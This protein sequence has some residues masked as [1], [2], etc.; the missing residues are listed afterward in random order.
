MLKRWAGMLYRNVGL[1]LLAA[2][3][4]LLPAC[5]APSPMGVYTVDA[6]TGAPVSDVHVE[7]YDK[8]TG[9]QTVGS[10]DAS[11]RLEGI[12]V[13]LGDRL[14]LSR[15]GY[16][17]RGLEIGFSEAKPLKRVPH[18]ESAKF[19]AGQFAHDPEDEAIPYPAD[20]TMIVPIHPTRN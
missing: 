16:E 13:K 18:S 2:F 20:R 12:A 14:K 17:T 7:R 3:A 11:G 15:T 5:A 9:T 19:P 1:M 4:A 10:T 6:I 8:K